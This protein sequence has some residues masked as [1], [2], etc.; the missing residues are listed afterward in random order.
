M[1]DV[2]QPR[3]DRRQPAARRA[4]GGNYAVLFGVSMIGILGFA[5]LAVDMSWLLLADNQAQNAADAAAHA[6]LIVLRNERDQT[7]AY[8]VAEA[9]LGMNTVVGDSVVVDSETTIVFGGWD[10]GT[11]TFDPAALYDNAIQVSVARNEGSS[12]GAVGLLLMPLL[13]RTT[14]NVW[15][16]ATSALRAREIMVALDI[17]ITWWNYGGET[18][19]F[20]GARDS[21][22]GLLEY[23]WN[24]GSPFPGD[25]L[26][27]VVYTGGAEEYAPM[28]YVA[29][30]YAS[31]YADWDDDE[32]DSTQGLERCNSHYYPWSTAYRDYDFETS[33]ID[34][35]YPLTESANPLYPGTDIE[36]AIDTAAASLNALGD[37]DALKSI[38]LV[39]EHSA[40]CP[41]TTLGSMTGT[42]TYSAACNTSRHT[43][44]RQAAN[45]A[46]ADDISIYVMSFNQDNIGL[47]RNRLRSLVK[48]RGFFAESDD[49]A[50]LPEMMESIALDIPIAL[51]Q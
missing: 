32:N 8:D 6:G 26:G 15:A 49:A 30:E 25:Q 41:S 34:C 39:A 14:G 46:D 12:Q 20:E 50:D 24:D 19:H 21:L 37:T 5:A 23:A 10:F 29:A 48:G 22:L 33:M 1:M 45:R 18:E 27:L 31:W 7:Q 2:H 16:Q 28:G 44:A 40:D 35:S 38:I 13:G 51:V 43:L 42:W 3:Q 47:H 11:K 4:R 36:E 9:V 17:S